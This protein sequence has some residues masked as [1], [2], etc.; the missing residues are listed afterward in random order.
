MP[1]RPFF[2][3]S[4]V[5]RRLLQLALGV[6]TAIGVSGGQTLYDFG[7]PTAEEQQY[8]EHINRSRAFPSDEGAKFAATTDPGVLYNYGAWQVDLVMMQNEFNALPPQPPLAP[9]AKL[10]TISRNHSAWMLANG[11][12]AHDET[13]PAKTFT[14]RLSDIGYPIT[15]AGENINAFAQQPW[16]G[17][18][19]LDVDWGNGTNGKVGGMQ[20]PRGHRIN[21]HSASYREI[22]VGVV[23]GS[24]TGPSGTVGPQLVTQDFGTQTSSPTFGTGVAYYDLNAN[25]AFDVGEGISGLTV[26]VSGASY[27]CASAIGGGWTVP[28]P[29]TG[30]TRTVTFTGLNVNQSVNLTV[31]AS[32]NAKADLKLPYT[33]P[34]ITSSPEVIGGTAQ[35]VSFNPVAGASGY[36]WS[37]SIPALAAAE[38]CESTGNVTI[39]KSG[40]YPVLNSNVKQQGGYAFHLENTTGSN[41]SVELNTLFHGGASPSLGFQSL[42]RYATTAE[43]FRVQIK[44]E[45]TSEWQDAYTQSGT[46][47][48]GEAGF[49]LRNVGLPGV[50]NKSFRVRFLL[51]SHGGYYATSG[52]IVGW[53]IDAISFTNVSQLNST[54]SESLAATSG[55]FTPSSGTTYLMAV[56]PVI[57]GRNFPAAYQTLTATSGVITPPS[58]SGQPVSVTISSGNTATFVVTATGTSP[59]YQWY[60]GA[61]GSTTNPV[62]G[63]TGSSFT[64]PALTNTTSY[65]V[66]VS[67]TAGTVDSTTAT[68]TVITPPA[69]TEQPVS[70]SIQNGG[71]A[72]FSVSATGSSPSYQW[73]AGISGVTT[74]P[75]AGANSSTYT[76]PAL[77]GSAS[78]WV[79]VSNAA[80]TQDSNTATAT[81][82]SP[83]SITGQPASTTIANGNS[84]V[85]SVSATGSGLSYQW[86][87]GSSGNTSNPIAGASAATYTTPALSTTSSYWV[88]VS[89]IAGAANSNTATATVNYPPAILAQP[90]STTITKGST[91]TI[92]VTAS[93]PSLT[94]QWYQ[95]NSGTTN[96]PVSGAISSSFTTP[97]INN[98]SKSYWVR[99]S[100][101]AGSVNSVTSQISTQNGAVTRNFGVWASEIETANGIAA[102]TLS[103]ANGDHDKDGRSNLIEYAFGASPI[104]A[105]DAAPRMPV[106]YQTATECFLQYQLD[107]TITDITVT[108][109]AGTDLNQWL[110]PGASGAPVGFSN[111]LVSTSGNLQTRKAVL[112]KSSSPRCLLRIQVTR[113]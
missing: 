54:V 3:H 74:S 31:P 88:R 92:S 108:P 5:G 35:T 15:A 63:A 50:A 90:V 84:A 14:N 27:Y 101:A 105:N 68:A 111:T 34:T 9:N 100:N 22:G 67:N 102:G 45:G 37:R 13:N 29:S 7:N 106:F 39:S 21:I 38:N 44:E 75:V 61:S 82:I 53:F 112:L 65:W 62:A 80:G 43:R 83:P 24:M 40:T 79:R 59:S 86:F 58:I 89:N 20:N 49:I 107:T 93:G 60:A 17:H 110:A 41:Q 12:Q 10:M 36:T 71:T 73:Y 69:I 95:G 51:S 48:S 81:V 66:R 96:S 103:N 87:A 76:T 19:A 6:Y 33:A 77:G 109:V 28:V 91:A 1:P 52:D 57:S 78:Y 94:Y 42:V 4:R 18:V 113:P 85:F 8:I 32:T 25:N 16:N 30:A 99:V 11:T 2:N 97:V 26:N 104:I 70:V 55:S 46:G 56:A 72:T 47:T 23:N 98:G 64:T